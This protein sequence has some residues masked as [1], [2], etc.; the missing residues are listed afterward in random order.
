MVTYSGRNDGRATL[1]AG[2]IIAAHLAVAWVWIALD[3]GLPDGDELGV[4]GAVELVW[5][6]TLAE[7]PLRAFLS[8]FVDDFGEYPGL[9]YA[10]TGVGAAISGVTA[11][12]GDG[13]LRVGLLWGALALA[14]TAWLGWEVGGSRRGHAAVWSAALLAASPL[15][16]ATQRHLLIENAL[17]AWVAL[18]AAALVRAQRRSGL[19]L[20][21]LS[22]VL[23]SVALLTKQT[24]VLVLVPLVVGVLTTRTNRPRPFSVV[25]PLVACGVALSVAGPWYLGRIAEEGSY[26]LSSAGANPGA[27]GLLRQVAYYPLVLLQQVWPPVIWVALFAVLWPVRHRLPR[28]LVV[29]GALSLVVLVGIPK[30]YPRLLLSLLPILAAGVGVGV[31]SAGLSKGREGASLGRGGA[32][33]LGALLGGTLLGT[34]FSTQSVVR[35]IGATDAGLRS[36]DERCIQRW[37]EAPVQPGLPWNDLIGAI[38]AQGV[39]R[40]GAIDWPSPPCEY[41]T[42]HDLGE[43]LWVRL[44]RAGSKMTIDAGASFL[45]ADGWP[46]GAPDLLITD[47]PLVCG[48]PAGAAGA[49]DPCDAA[50]FEPI[51]TFP[52][53]HESWDLDLRLHRRVE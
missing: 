5:S 27:A 24:A 16:S 14:G 26:L 46:A 20:W 13:P 22:G 32:V 33:A 25:G 29:A 30:K 48:E 36:L 21:A 12:D 50:R 9:H 51:A 38:E 17:C 8:V 41:Q 45:Q 39:R 44:R 49:G 42:S 19:H 4:L 2:A 31:A 35:M 37:I 1:G 7:G 28:P 18:C 11:L 43:H 23:G 52:Y 3:A 34:S 40:V 15:W 6:R 10:F 47:G 53:R